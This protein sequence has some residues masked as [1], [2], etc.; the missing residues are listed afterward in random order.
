M[1][2][3]I[4]SFSTIRIFVSNV[5]ASREWYKSLFEQEPIVDIENFVSFQISNTYFDISLADSKSPLSTGGAVGYWLADN[6]DDLLEKVKKL[7]GKVY[8]GPL[9]ITKTQR[10][11]VQIQDPF[12]NVIGFEAPLI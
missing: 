5:A 1:N 7:D 2:F 6:L 8:R 4:K 10:T 9:I 12:G 3:K 11:I